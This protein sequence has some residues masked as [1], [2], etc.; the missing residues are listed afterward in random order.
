MGSPVI[1]Q[2]RLNLQFNTWLQVQVKVSKPGA[3]G[4]VPVGAIIGSV[5]GGL[6][7]LALAVALLW[8]VLYFAVYSVYI[9][10]LSSLKI[11][12][13]FTFSLDSSRGSISRWWTRL[14][15]ER[16]IRNCR[17]TARHPKKS[18]ETHLAISLLPSL[19]MITRKGLERANWVFK[20]WQFDFSTASQILAFKTHSSLMSFSPAWLECWCIF[21]AQSYHFHSFPE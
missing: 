13:L 8:K 10:S 21:L 6:L 15:M 11:H 9:L 19:T 12:A 3:K 17:K 5:I 20:N 18:A 7:L 16:K 14:R 1:T 2:C 4:D